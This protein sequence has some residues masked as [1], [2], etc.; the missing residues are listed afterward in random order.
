MT[1]SLRL[2]TR[3]LVSIPGN[4]RARLMAYLPQS[5]PLPYD[6]KVRDV[7]LLG[8]APHRSL[9]GMASK[10]DHD[11]VSE[12]MRACEV[13]PFAE[14]GILSLSGGERQ[15]VMLARLLATRTPSLFLDEP[16]AALDVGHTL[17]TCQH[18]RDLADAGRCVVVAMHELNL[19]KRFADSVI[20]LGRFSPPSEPRTSS[21]STRASATTAGFAS[22]PVL[23]RPPPPLPEARAP[24]TSSQQ[25]VC[26]PV[27]TTPPVGFDGVDSPQLIS[28]ISQKTL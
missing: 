1:G 28:P 19:A 27:G 13:E 23:L 24:A 16:A 10:E 9:F 5:Q 2:G 12:A 21:T 26:P 14:R 11:A 15:R 7:V 22:P 6:R 3:D 20:L 18:L 4:E 25:T 8:R 17:R